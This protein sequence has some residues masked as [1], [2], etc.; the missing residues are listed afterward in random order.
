L[1]DEVEQFRIVTL[2]DVFFFFT[3]F[4]LFFGSL[5]STTCDASL[6]AIETLSAVAKNKPKKQ[7]KSEE[8]QKTNLRVDSSCTSQCS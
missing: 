5:T 1:L 2:I 7:I 6:L 4:L 3:F 8:R